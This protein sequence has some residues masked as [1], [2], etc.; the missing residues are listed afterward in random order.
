ME[1]RQPIEPKEIKNPVG[2]DSGLTNFIYLSDSTHIENPKFIKQHEKRIKKAQKSLSKKKKGSKNRKKAKS[3]L[4]KR[5]NDYNNIKDDWQWKLS[6][7]LVSK[8][9]LIAYE[10]LIIKNMVKNHSLA[11]SIQDASWGSFWGKVE[12]KA[13]QNETL[14]VAVEPKYSTQECPICHVN[15]KVALSERTFTCPSCGYTAQRDYKASIILLQRAMVGMGMPEFTPAEIPPA[16]HHTG[17]SRVSLKQETSSHIA[18][19]PKPG[20]SIMGSSRALA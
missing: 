9:D 19:E 5:W 8:Y 12:W 4:A 20:D 16:G 1:D 18:D 11:K 3:K 7:M 10:N 17:V 13:K 15:H 14:A 2:V 6:N